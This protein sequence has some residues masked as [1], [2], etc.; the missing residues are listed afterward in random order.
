MHRLARVSL[1]FRAFLCVAFLALSLVAVAQPYVIDRFHVDIALRAD[2]TMTVNEEIA[3]TFNEPRRGIFRVIPI[4]YDTGKGMSRRIFLTNISVVDDQANEQTTKISHEGENINIRIGDADVYLPTNTKKVYR[5]S[6]DARNMINWF[7]DATD[8]EP[9]A[10]LYWNLT[11]DQWD[12]TIV[13]PSFKVTFPD[14]SDG[15]GVRARLF[16]G[17]YGSR[18]NHVLS[19]LAKNSYGASTDTTISLERDSVSGKRNSA[20]EPYAGLTLVLNVPATLIKKPTTMEAAR[21]LVLANAGLTLPIFVLAFMS[22]LWF[23]FGRD[24]KQGPVVVRYDPPDDLSGPECGALIDERVDQRDI[25]AGIV[26][27]A[28]KGFL[29]V[30][31]IEEGLIFKKRTASLHLTG[32]T[33][34]APLTS[35]E[36]KLYNLLAAC[37]TDIQPEDLRTEVAPSLSSLR[38]SLYGCLKSHGFYLRSP[39]G[40]RI[41]WTVGGIVLIGALAFLSLF[42]SPFPNVVAALIGGGLSVVILLIFAPLMPRRTHKGAVAA[43]AVRGFEEFMRRARADDLKWMSEKHPNEAMFEQYLPHAVAFGLTEQWSAAFRDIV[44]VPPRWY[45]TPAGTHFHA[46]WLGNDLS[47]VTRSLAA[48]AATPPRSSGSSGGSSGFSSGGGFSGGGFG[49]GGGGSW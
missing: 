44:T 31:P 25:A 42:V 47:T 3:V 46:S 6:Y 43:H 45:D 7:E 34:F 23:K 17:S 24:T 22:L 35:F 5:I 11:G 37:G 9:Y 30:K 12:T 2:G 39:E 32:E 20:L 8:W 36:K 1:G 13:A 10:E 21:D 33:N 4:A 38:E 48:A 40:V 18:D 28:V 41:G 16:A 27:L 14:T 49:G 29:T 19:R 26:S 15:R